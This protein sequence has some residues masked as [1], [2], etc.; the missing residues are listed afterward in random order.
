MAPV[1][2]LATGS[3]PVTPAVSDTFVIV[4]LLPEI[5][6]LVSVSVPA[7]VA[8]TPPLTVPVALS[9]PATAKVLPEPT[10]KPT[11]VPV[12]S[13]LKTASRVSMSELSLPPQV[14]VEEP[15]SGFV[16][17]RFGV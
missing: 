14:S 12:P 2:P 11:E 17:L 15:T 5:V 16:K 7:W 8:I 9:V 1:P 10:F 13:D 3:V 6:L 4:L